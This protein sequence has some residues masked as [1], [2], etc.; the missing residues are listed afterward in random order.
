ME[1]AHA[2]G[3]PAIGATYGYGR[4]GELDAADIRIT[5]APDL[6]AAIGHLLRRQA[7]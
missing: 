4:E 1:A 2:N 3:I 6:P 5:R 7:S